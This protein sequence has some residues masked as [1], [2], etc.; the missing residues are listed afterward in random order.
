MFSSKLNIRFIIIFIRI[1]KS[2]V[3]NILPIINFFFNNIFIFIIEKID[4]ILSELEKIKSC[5][6]KIGEYESL[7]HEK[8]KI[9]TSIKKKEAQK[10]EIILRL[11]DLE[12]DNSKLKENIDK[13]EEIT[14][15]LA[16]LREKLQEVKAGKEHK[17][18]LLG[19]EVELK[20]NN[21][22]YLHIMNLKDNKSSL[23][24]NINKLEDDISIIEEGLQKELPELD[25]Y[26]DLSKIEREYDNKNGKAVTLIIFGVVLSIFGHPQDNTLLC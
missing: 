17:T 19:N 5:K 21:D 2:Q 24:Q 6:N 4:N 9:I 23:E 26:S 10:E 7:I 18:N 14:I 22:K 11:K 3:D 20:K 25:D 13:I 8:T 12:H 16:R 1:F 15:H